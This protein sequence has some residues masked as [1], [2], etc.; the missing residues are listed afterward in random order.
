[1]LDACGWLRLKTRGIHLAHIGDQLRDVYQSQRGGK[2]AVDQRSSKSPERGL[3]F[4]MGGGKVVSIHEK[5]RDS[6]AGDHNRR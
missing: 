2:K 4:I 3:A 5:T 6:S 1:M